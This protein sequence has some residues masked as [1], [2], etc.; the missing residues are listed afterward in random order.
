LDDSIQRKF[1]PLI[2]ENLKLLKGVLDRPPYSIHGESGSLFL[3]NGILHVRSVGEKI[4]RKGLFLG[5]L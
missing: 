2:G 1:T 3:L 5:R 4:M